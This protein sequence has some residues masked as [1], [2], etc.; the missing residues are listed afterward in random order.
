MGRNLK[1][2]IGNL[3]FAILAATLATVRLFGAEVT[4]TIQPPLI[5]LSESATLS[6]EVREAKNPQRPVLPDVPGLQFTSAGQSQSSSWVNGKTDRFT[7]FNFKIYPQKSGTFTIGPFEYKIDG[8][9]KTLQGELKV[10]GTSGEVS[11]PQSWSDI[12]FSRIEIDRES[13]Y[14]QE[15]FGLTLSIYSRQGVQLAGNINLTGMPETGLDGLQWQEMQAGRDLIDNVVYDIRRFQTRTRAMSSGVF[16]FQPVITVQVVVPN[17]QRNQDPFFG[18]LFQRTETRPVDL[19]VEKAS[20]TVQPLPAE[21]RPPG[22]S[23]AVGQ[24][25]FQMSAHPLAVHPGDPVTLTMI[26]SGDGNSD[27][28]MSPPLPLNGSFR[29]FGEPIRKQES[30]AVRFEQVISPRSA[31]VTEIPS[32]PFSFFDTQS[33]RYRTVNSPAI[34]ITVMEASN[35]TAQIFVSKESM[36]LPPPETPFATE[37]DLQRIAARLKSLWMNIR[38]WLWTLPAALTLALAIFLGQRI[39]KAQQSDTARIRR[40]KAPQAAR[41]ALRA[42]RHAQRKGDGAAFYDALWNALTDYFGHRLNLPPGDVTAAT[43]LRALSRAGMDP[44]PIHA[45]RHVFEQVE[46]SRYGLP[47]EKSPEN[48]ENL[49]NSLEQILRRCEKSKL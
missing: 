40:Q 30:H 32:I 33:G 9:T 46:A 35:S 36:V 41:K 1:L 19:P 26:V 27:R 12:V 10:V 18:S 49:Q 7:A 5:Q 31:D 17:Q 8:E 25:D 38:P 45:L 3:K 44:E 48:M 23:G 22:F 34:P 47:V 39:Y 13:A 16:E 11:Q 14:V 6:I 24:F 21:G 42:A 43:V 29:L 37:S 4:M 2:E 28:V 20:I 15:P